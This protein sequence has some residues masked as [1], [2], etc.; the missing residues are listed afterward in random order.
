MIGKAGI[1]AIQDYWLA[2]TYIETGCLQQ[3][4]ELRTY[5]RTVLYSVHTRP[6]PALKDEKTRLRA[7]DR[8][9]GFARTLL[10]L[11]HRANK[12]SIREFGYFRG[13]PRRDKSLRGRAAKASPRAAKASRPIRVCVPKPERPRASNWPGNSRRQRPR[14]SSWSLSCRP[15]RT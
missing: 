6:C 3:L 4:A 5:S 15:P 1:S 13:L 7:C 10:K 8:C 9:A 12:M 2:S 14:S 11:H